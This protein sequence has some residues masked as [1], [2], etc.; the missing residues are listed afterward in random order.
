MLGVIVLDRVSRRCIWVRYCC[1]DTLATIDTRAKWFSW[2]RI[3]DTMYN[4]CESL[5]NPWLI[6]CSI[7][8]PEQAFQ[9]PP[10]RTGGFNDTSSRQSWHFNILQI[11]DIM[12][13]PRKRLLD[14]RWARRGSLGEQRQTKRGMVMIPMK[15]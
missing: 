11:A 2:I 12:I 9:D 15:L 1:T 6:F 7:H 3:T 10:K 4:L 5:V 14:L 8:G 13:S